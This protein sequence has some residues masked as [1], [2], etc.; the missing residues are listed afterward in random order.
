MHNFVPGSV[1]RCV[2]SKDAMIT[3][4][5]DYTIV[6]AYEWR[7]AVVN[8]HGLPCFYGADRFSLV[9]RGIDPSVVQSMIALVCM[10]LTKVVDHLEADRV[11]EAK[12]LIPSCRETMRFALS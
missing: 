4:N 7:V 9:K 3:K 5:K 1:V 11:Q 10:S 12:E 6:A 2:R 8:D